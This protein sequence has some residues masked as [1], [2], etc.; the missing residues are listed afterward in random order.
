MYYVLKNVHYNVCIDIYLSIVPERGA[1]TITL[2]EFP[3][4]VQK[5]QRR[6]DG[7]S[8]L[9]NEYEV[10][11][12]FIFIYVLSIFCVQNLRYIPQSTCKVASLSHNKCGNR[13]KNILPCKKSRK[14]CIIMCTMLYSFI[15]R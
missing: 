12:F 11:F 9:T 5:M 13:F 8:M 6:E 3:E 15:R 1:C 2:T 4:Y 7:M 14:I 10:S